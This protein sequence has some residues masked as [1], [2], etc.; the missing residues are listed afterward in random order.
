MNYELYSASEKSS[1]ATHEFN[2]DHCIFTEF[3]FMKDH[4]VRLIVAADGMGG[5]HGGKEA[6]KNAITGFIQLLYKELLQSY[7][8]TDMLNF[9]MKYTVE[10]VCQAMMQAMKEANNEVCRQADPFLATGSTLSA[11]CVMDDFAIVANVGDSPV[12]YYKK[13]S[14]QLTLVSERHTKAEMDVKAGKYERFSREYYNNAHILYSSLGEY[15]DLPEA[16]VYIKAIGGI[17]PGDILLAGTDGAFGYLGE[18]VLSS[19]IEDY[20]PGKG[21]V[22]LK[23]LFDFASIDHQDDQTAVLYVFKERGTADENKDVF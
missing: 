8:T 20:V 4:P 18:N 3:S 2:E 22:L 6:S 23:Q 9:S 14:R 1:E 19:L 11:V 13:K 12:Y 10:K 16:S 15:S 21:D 7:M 5:L 17:E